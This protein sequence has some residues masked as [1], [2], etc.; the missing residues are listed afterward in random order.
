MVRCDRQEGQARC[1]EP[2]RTRH[3]SNDELGRPPDLEMADP[4]K[5]NVS[6][7]PIEQHATDAI[8]YTFTENDGSPGNLDSFWTISL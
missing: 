7:R 3:T 8:V 1:A 4:L 2:L 5:L 6:C